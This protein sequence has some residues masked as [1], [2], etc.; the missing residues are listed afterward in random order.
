MHSLVN[1]MTD[2][3]TEITTERGKNYGHP[4]KHFATT[5]AMF[6][7]WREARLDTKAASKLTTQQEMALRHGVYMILDK[8]ARMSENPEHRDNIDDIQGYAKCI[9][10]VLDYE[11]T[12]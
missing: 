12:K 11:A 6:C 10:M 8:L 7:V 3:I 5:T 2:K 9:G 4:I 1:D